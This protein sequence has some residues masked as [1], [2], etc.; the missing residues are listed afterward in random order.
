[1]YFDGHAAG[2]SFDI[3]QKIQIDMTYPDQFKVTGIRETRSV[4]VVK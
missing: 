4:N 3:S 1:V 2:L